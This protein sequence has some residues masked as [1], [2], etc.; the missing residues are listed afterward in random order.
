MNIQSR[1]AEDV[2][3]ICLFYRSGSVLTRQMYTTARDVREL[4]LLR[5][6]ETFHP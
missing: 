6:I 2:P 1:F 5:G 4:E 3:F